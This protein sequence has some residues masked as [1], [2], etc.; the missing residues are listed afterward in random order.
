MHAWDCSSF[1]RG[2]L[3]PTSILF[4]ILY[5]AFIS[6]LFRAA[7]VE[8]LPLVWVIACGGGTEELTHHPTFRFVIEIERGLDC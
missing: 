7:P 8:R 3:D 4:T 2:R 1:P 6:V 5:C